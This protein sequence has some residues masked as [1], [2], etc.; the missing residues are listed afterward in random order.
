MAL[1]AHKSLDN[2]L[3]FIKENE[4]VDPAH[5]VLKAKQFPEMPIREIAE[6][7]AARKKAKNKLPEWYNNPKLLF[8]PSLSMEQCS[9]EATAKFKASIASGENL[10]DL[11]GGF[12]I[13]TYY[14]SQGFEKTTYVEQQAH[15]CE[16]ASYN[17]S[18]LNRPIVVQHQ[19]AAQFLKENT[20]QF[21]WIYIDPARRDQNQKKVSRWQDCSPDLTIVLPALLKKADNILVK[22]A[23]MLDISLGI[24]DLQDYVR[25][26]YVVEW[27][28]EVRE[29]LFNLTHEK[30][31]NPEITAVLL[32]DNGEIDN[33]FSGNKAEEQDSRATFSLPEAHLLEPSPALMKAGLY[34]MLSSKFNLHKLHQNTQLFISLDL[35][36]QFPGRCF[37]ILETLPANKKALKKVLPD[38]KANLSTRN[39][40]LGVQELKKKLGLKDG[41]DKYIFACTLQDE[42][43]K[44]LVCEK[45]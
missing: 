22:G 21:N 37:K 40:P 10:A 11:S 15:L 28:G 35:P 5:L 9:S 19:E 8:P 2:I 4:Q 13:D 36:A 34:K 6:Q 45:A 24:Q 44:L 1:S 20:S 25:K 33:Q 17:F 3:Q 23:P 12:G 27:R 41:G 31:T 14:L 18:Q 32:A 26:V 38:M 7:I 42:S 29:L 39:F 30:N 43:K 16:L